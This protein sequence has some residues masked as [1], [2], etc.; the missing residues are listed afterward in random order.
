MGPLLAEVERAAEIIQDGHERIAAIVHDLKTFAKRDVQ[1]IKLSDLHQGL[2][3]TLSL[4][5]HELGDRVKVIR[6]FGDIGLV[7]ADSA[8]INQVFLNLIHNAMQAIPESGSIIIKT[9]KD[10]ERVFISVKDTGAGIDP[11]HLPRIFEPFFTTKPVGQGTGLGL[12]V[13]HRII[14]EHG[15]QMTVKSVVGRGTEFVI[16]L[17]V[18]QTVAAATG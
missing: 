5:R 6:E 1:G 12:S 14:S 15:G 4:L 2:D 7:E 10:G 3:A 8:Q 11:E 17:P 16:E 13:S 9:W 18:R